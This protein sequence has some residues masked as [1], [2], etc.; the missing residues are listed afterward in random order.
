MLVRR[1]AFENAG[2]ERAGIDDR[3]NLTPEEFRVEGE[4]SSP[5]GPLYGDHALTELVEE[6]E[7]RGLVYF[8]DFF[9]LTG[10]WPGW[11]RLLG[12]TDER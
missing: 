7:R 3:F 5:S 2:L 9:E 11:L 10:N 8:D 4:G 1:R 12:M 6:L